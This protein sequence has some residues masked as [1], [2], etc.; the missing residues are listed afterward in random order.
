VSSKGRV[1]LVDDEV[2]LARA[3]SRWL[4]LAGFE[5]SIAEDGIQAEKL[6]DTM[7]RFDV[8]VSDVVMP[9]LSG[10]GLLRSIRDKDTD[11]P[12]ILATARPDLDTA[13]EAI[14][15]GIIRY[16]VKPVEST[17][18]QLA[19]EK[20]VRYRR[21]ADL[22][23]RALELTQQ[24]SAPGDRLS[25]E[26]SFE[27]MLA[28]LHLN[29]Q[30]IVS[31]SE[32]KVFAYEALMR[33]REPAIPHP[34]AM[35]DAA[36]RLE[37][38][39]E[40]GRTVR[41]RAAEAFSLMPHGTHLF[42]NLHPSDLSDPDLYDHD[43]PLSPYAQRVV[44]EITERAAL[45]SITQLKAKIAALRGLGYQIAVD[46]LGAGYAGL[47]SFAGLEP[48]V[49]KIDMSLVRDIE[50]EK[51]KQMLVEAIAEVCKELKLLVI[52]EGVE[53]TEEAECLVASG[54]DLLQGYRF[55]KPAALFAVPAGFTV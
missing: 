5:V 54:C 2:A 27:K 12:V 24:E 39:P 23:R 7:P 51:T 46:D 15:L 34:G 44:L 40:L 26:V 29:F 32:H 52:A 41:R 20:A 37:R 45:D 25:L 55:A 36:E 8:I 17:V 14:E 6:I 16:L 33:S 11:V 28:G 18:L 22:K 13:V 50:K 1:L 47:A 49:V 4:S 48:E 53:T 30:P 9:N 19:V 35:L 3:W 21:L 42:V 38:L 43:S 10:I 31:V